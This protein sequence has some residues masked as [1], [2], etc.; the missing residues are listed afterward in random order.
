MNTENREITLFDVLESCPKNQTILDNLVRAWAI[1]NNAKYEK[2]VCTIS[3]GV[4]LM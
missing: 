1:I 3:G 2:I 4:I